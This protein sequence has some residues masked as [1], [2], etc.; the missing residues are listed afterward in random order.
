M[1]VFAEKSERERGNFLPVGSFDSFTF[2]GQ[3][4]VQFGKFPTHFGAGNTATHSTSSLV[5]QIKQF[6]DET[7][8]CSKKD[9]RRWFYSA[10]WANLFSEHDDSLRFICDNMKITKPSPIM[11]DALE[12]QPL[13]GPTCTHAPHGSIDNSDSTAYSIIY[14]DTTVRSNT[15]L[16]N[17]THYPNI[18]SILEMV[19]EQ[20]FLSR[21]RLLSKSS[22]HW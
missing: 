3:E 5:P 14:S 7:F 19:V 11:R 8:N 22:G 4:L 17:N 20:F 1:D 15:K 2:T 9:V 10:P 18:C 6:F 13:F 21:W 12:E 16:L